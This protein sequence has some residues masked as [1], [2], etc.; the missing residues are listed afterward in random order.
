MFESDRVDLHREIEIV[1]E[2]RPPSMNDANRQVQAQRWRE[3]RE[4]RSTAQAVASEAAQRWLRRHAGIRWQKLDRCSL[5]VVFIVPRR[6]RRDWDNL[7]STIKP[8]LDGIVDAGVIA[9]D[10]Q[11]CIQ[12]VTL[13]IRHE[14]GRSATI[15]AFTEVYE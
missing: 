9:D 4:W 15:L 1:I 5:D 13:S 7:T 3:R 2:G 14:K 8:L 12:T 6:G 10:S 11:E